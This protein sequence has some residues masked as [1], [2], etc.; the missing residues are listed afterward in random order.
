MLSW[1]THQN[2]GYVNVFKLSVSLTTEVLETKRTC[3][4]LELFQAL[5]RIFSFSSNLAFI[6]LIKD[7]IK[8]IWEKFTKLHTLDENVHYN[9]WIARTRVIQFSLQMPFLDCNFNTIFST[10]NMWRILFWKIK[11][12]KLIGGMF[13]I[14]YISEKNWV[15]LI[16]F[17]I[18]WLIGVQTNYQ[19]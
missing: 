3:K 10:K 14:C 15:R 4:F 7:S 8:M 19:N 6:F 11:T 9:I 17:H 16:E 12:K 13:T 1:L 18:L 2:P 5:I